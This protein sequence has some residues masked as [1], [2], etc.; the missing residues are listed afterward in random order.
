MDQIQL[1]FDENGEFLIAQFTDIHWDNASENNSLTRESINY[2]LESQRPDLV[3][4]TGDIVTEPPAADGW[5]EI[6]M[7]FEEAEIPWCVTLGNHDAEIDVS[8]R[9]EIFTILSSYPHF[10]G[11][12][13]H[14]EVE[15]AGNYLLP[16]IGNRDDNTHFLVYAIDTHNKP[17][18]DYYGHYDWIKLNQIEWYRSV[19]DNFTRLNNDRPLPALAFMH[20]PINEYYNIVDK[21][22]TVGNR[23]E[24]LP[25]L[26]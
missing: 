14:P 7:I 21:A 24:E 5:N 2:V 15:G 13:G 19:S 18:D 16:I 12:A 17:T 1:R 11:E 10:V 6:A 4:L 26:I 3:T 25:P 22:N 8:D 9:Q 20:I 23:F